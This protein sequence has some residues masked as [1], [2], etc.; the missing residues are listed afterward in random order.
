M[1]RR[2]LALEHQREVRLRERGR[3]RHRE[4]GACVVKRSEIVNLGGL[5][6]EGHRLSEGSETL[7]LSSRVQGAAPSL[8]MQPDEPVEARYG[9]AKTATLTILRGRRSR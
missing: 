4:G 3:A 6:L 2:L 8:Q 9:A 7:G 5:W 1:L